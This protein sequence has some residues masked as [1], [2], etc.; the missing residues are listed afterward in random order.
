[1]QIDKLVHWWAVFV[2]I[3]THELI[4]SS[5]GCGQTKRS[6]HHPTPNDLT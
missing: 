2:G 4:I 6:L 3:A 1:M 5:A